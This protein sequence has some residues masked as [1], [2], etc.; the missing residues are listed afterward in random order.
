MTAVELL[1]KNHTPSGFSVW[2]NYDLVFIGSPCC[3]A[4]LHGS[5]KF[6]YLWSCAHC[7]RPYRRTASAA[8][9]L[10]TEDTI[11]GSQPEMEEWIS[12]W[13]GYPISRLVVSAN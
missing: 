6:D 12:Q 10:L 3:N 11:L 4:R 2:Q 9:W 1:S 8:A 7:D 13:T 5:S